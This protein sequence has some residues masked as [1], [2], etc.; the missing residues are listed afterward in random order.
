M[1][2]LEAETRKERCL[3]ACHLCLLSYLSYVTQALLTRDDITDSGPDILYQLATKALSHRHGHGQ[4]NLDNSLVVVLF[5]QGTLGFS[6]V[7]K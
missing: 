4:S 1:Q 6:Q 3:L 7:D 5:Y 2:E